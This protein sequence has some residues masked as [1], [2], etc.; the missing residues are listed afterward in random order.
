MPLEASLDRRCVGRY[1]HHSSLPLLAVKSR[2]DGGRV[3]KIAA[4]IAGC[5]Q[6]KISGRVDGL[7]RLLYCLSD[8][9]IWGLVVE[10]TDGDIPA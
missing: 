7:C 1:L 6:P 4:C 10:V 8:D 9:K 3:V 5:I 2:E